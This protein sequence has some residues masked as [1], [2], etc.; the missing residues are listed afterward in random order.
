MS[1]WGCVLHTSSWKSHQSIYVSLRNSFLFDVILF[2]FIYL[3][4][5]YFVIRSLIPNCWRS[6]IC[7][8]V[9]RFPVF[10]PNLFYRYNSYCGC[11]L[12]FFF[13]FSLSASF[14]IFFTEWVVCFTVII[15]HSYSYYYN[16]Y[17]YY[18][19]HYH[20][21]CFCLFKMLLRNVH[22]ELFLIFEYITK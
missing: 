13:M 16:Y 21:H 6:F 19:H 20:L 8:F 17:F 12:F 11:Q 5:L 18:H 3:F 22:V 2:L 7:S 1:V 9:Y 15:Y 14:K 10:C 4:F